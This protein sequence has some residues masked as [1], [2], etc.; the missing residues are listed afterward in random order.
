[1][2]QFK[3]ETA[4]G[5][6]MGLICFMLVVGCPGGG[7]NGDSD[8]EDSSN[9]GGVVDTTTYFGNAD[10]IIDYYDYDF[11]GNLFFIEQKSYRYDVEVETGP[12]KNVGSVIE[13]NAFNLQV[14]TTTMGGEGTF[15]ISSAILNVALQ[16][17]PVLL[18]Y[19]DFDYANNLID[20]ELV[21]THIAESAAANQIYAWED[22]SGFVSVLLFFMDT[23]TTIN[24]SLTA[25]TADIQIDGQTTDGTRVFSIDIQAQAI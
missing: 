21:N 5:L 16:G 17:A 22:L 2:R 19:W 10:I 15:G 7:G 6:I 24:G 11:F 13:Q 9:T 3:R 23:G 20:G 18:E 12:P 14:G 8:S 4:I 1:M 25:D